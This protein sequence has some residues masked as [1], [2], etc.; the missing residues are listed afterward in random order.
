MQTGNGDATTPTEDPKMFNRGFNLQVTDQPGAQEP[1]TPQLDFNQPGVMAQLAP[2]GG[3][4]AMSDP[5]TGK[6]PIQ[7]AAPPPPT[8]PFDFLIQRLRNANDSFLRNA[9]EGRRSSER[10]NQE[11]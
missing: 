8:T 2:S 3:A 7:Q 6:T 10:Y 9:V 11:R 5:D 1:G 4:L